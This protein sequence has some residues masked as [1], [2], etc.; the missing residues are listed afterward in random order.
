[1]AFANAFALPRSDS[2]HALSSMAPIVFP[3]GETLSRPVG[4]FLF[5]PA[6]GKVRPMETIDETRRA[7]LRL[8]GDKF[9]SMAELCQQLGYAR[10]ETASLTR[11]LNANVRHDREGSP[12]YNMGD[13]IAR[14]I[15]TKLGI[16]R[17]WMDSPVSYAELD[18]MISDLI[19][20]ARQLREENRNDELA[21]LVRVGHTFVEQHPKAANGKQ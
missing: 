5:S 19:Q 12:T 21:H 9:G 13:P 4:E 6:G 8:L 17:G 14:F 20:V 10:T 3:K 7:R 2:S 15:E 11:I 16:E 1:M 18:P